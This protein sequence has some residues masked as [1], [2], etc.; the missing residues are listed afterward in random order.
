M[1]FR[2]ERS[3]VPAPPVVGT[4]VLWSDVRTAAALAARL[5]SLGVTHVL[6]TE[7]F[8]LGYPSPPEPVLRSFLS[9]RGR[10]LYRHGRISVWS[11]VP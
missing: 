5:R 7:N 9:E 11:V 10:L 8:G 6:T 3:Y 4:A 1:E 2:L